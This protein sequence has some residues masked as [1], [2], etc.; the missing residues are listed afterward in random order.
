MKQ[1]FILLALFSINAFAAPVNIN[2]AD[3]KTISESLKGIGPKKAEEII[4]YRTT[5]GAFKTLSDLTHVKGIGDKTVQKN[6][7]DI[8]FSDAKSSKKSN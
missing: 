5:K 4:Q 8:L 7:D 6:A 2:T 3:A 1:L